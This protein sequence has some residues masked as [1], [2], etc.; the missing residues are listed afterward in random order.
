MA[1][2]HFIVQQNNKMLYTQ[3][4]NCALMSCCAAS[5][6][7]SLPTFRENL[8]VPSLRTKNFCVFLTLG[9]GNPLWI[10]DLCRWTD[11]LSRNVGKEPLLAA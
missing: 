6:S 2:H 7:N 3:L 4:E 10:L 1:F 11:R 8:L 9:N 5:S